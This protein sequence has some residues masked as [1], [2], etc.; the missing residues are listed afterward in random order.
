MDFAAELK[1]PYGVSSAGERIWANV[2]VREE[3]Y[4]C[5]DCGGEL[6]LRRGKVVRPHF[7]HRVIPEDC[8]FVNESVAHFEAKYRIKE[9]I[10]TGKKIAFV[11]KCTTCDSKI[12]QPLPT[13]IVRAEIEYTLG[14][15]HRADVG[16]FDK[17]DKLR[18]VV[19]VYATHKVD[20]EKAEALGK[21]EIL[22]A[23]IE[24]REILESTLWSLVRDHFAQAECGLCKRREM[25]KERIIVRPLEF[26]NRLRFG[27]AR[28]HPV[29]KCPLKAGEEVDVFETCGCCRYFI[30]AREEGVHC[31]A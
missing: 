7:A 17:A 8:D 11:R 30:E 9:L 26:R 27:K 14:T 29:V 21:A 31:C 20:D 12:K 23:E 19:E 10:D 2:A 22:W 15:G 5:P 18:A 13:D 28:K 25:N 4:R 16:L 1:V 3:T 24:A 6:V